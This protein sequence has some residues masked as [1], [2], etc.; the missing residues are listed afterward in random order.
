MTEKNNIDTFANPKKNFLICKGL[1]NLKE[2]DILAELKSREPIFHHPDK[3]GR[4]KEGFYVLIPV[5]KPDFFLSLV[6]QEI[7]SLSYFKST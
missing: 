7:G 6:Q 2:N 3:F 5:G 4:T 1:A